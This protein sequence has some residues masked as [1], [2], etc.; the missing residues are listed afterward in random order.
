MLC[1]YDHVGT[2]DTMWHSKNKEEVVWKKGETA[3]ENWLA[4]ADMKLVNILSGHL[5]SGER[6]KSPPIS[7]PGEI[8]LPIAL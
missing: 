4:F 5:K 2:K 3:A 7:F 1:E 6:E 8:G